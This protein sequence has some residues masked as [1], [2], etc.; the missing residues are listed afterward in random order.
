MIFSLD[1]P[2]KSFFTPSI[3]VK[4]FSKYLDIPAERLAEIVLAEEQNILNNTKPIPNSK[5]HT[6]ITERLWQ[7]NLLDLDYDEIRSLKEFIKNSYI[8]Y[9]TELNQPIGKTYIQCWTNILRDNGRKIVPHH[10]ADGHSWGSYDLQQYS[11]LSGNICIQTF[12][13]N[14][15]YQNPF[16]DKQI[17]PLPNKNGEMIF[18]PSFIMH[19]TDVNKESVPRITISFDIITE[20]FYN[21]IDGSNYRELT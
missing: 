20:E 17:I 9:M 10:H 14:T 3:S 15:Y 12:G 7:Y 16:L 5:D 6:W 21:Q 2:S 8:E 19:W 11:Y 13:T 4:L 1:F 18:F